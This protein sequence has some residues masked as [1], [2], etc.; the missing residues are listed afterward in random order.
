M[1]LCRQCNARNSD[2]SNFCGNCGM[3]LGRV[4]PVQGG[5]QT[6]AG[7]RPHARQAAM[8]AAVSMQE[9]EKKKTS[10]VFWIVAGL[11]VVVILAS[12]GSMSGTTTASVT[13]NSVQ[14][15]DSNNEAVL[16]LVEQH[17]DA[18]DF[19]AADHKFQALPRFIEPTLRDRYEQAQS[20]IGSGLVAA[21]VSGF[22]SSDGTPDVQ[23]ARFRAI[24]DRVWS[25]YSVDDATANRFGALLAEYVRKLPASELSA[26]ADGYQLLSELNPGEESYGLKAASYRTKATEARF[27]EANRKVAGILKNYRA[28]RDEFNG[29]SFYRHVN[30]PRYVN[31]RS[32][33]WLYIGRKDD[34]NWLRMKTS[35]SAE[36]WL[37]VRQVRVLVDGETFELTAGRFKTDHDSRIWEWKD[38][39]P[40]VMQLAVLKRMATGSSVK[41]RYV[42]SN[43]HRDITL[44]AADK[45]ALRDVL[46]DFDQLQAL[47]QK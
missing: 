42:G 34:F 26:N 23:L 38:E 36:D 28:T 11:L 17:L 1:K 35:Y 47:K 16:A 14:K 9:P 4:A 6:A 45:R 13:P 12:F 21:F 39:T 18:G 31:S 20:K 19:E 41:L 29:S 40:S 15:R 44:G 33:V 10:P 46:N 27:A 2:K 32:T 43:Y 8:A 24:Y 7:R 3:A 25:R 30:S 5:A 37:F 22:V